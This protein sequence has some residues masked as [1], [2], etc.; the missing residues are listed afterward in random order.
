M[1][2]YLR[3]P[4]VQNALALYS[5]QV[6]EYLLPMITIPY[7]ARVLQPAAWGKIVYAQNF[8]FWIVMV[9]EYGFGFSASREIARHPGEAER[10]SELASGVAGAN[11]MLLAPALLL[12][13]I[14]RFT[15]PEF[16]DN[17][18]YLWLAAGIAVT[19]G[20]RPF[21]YFQGIERM[22][23]P[24]WMN[25]FGRFL[26]AAGIFALIRSAG[27]GWIVLTLQLLSGLLV[28]ALLVTSMYR[29]ISFRWP[30]FERSIAA[31]KVGW[32]IFLAR[33][34]TSL[35]TL[36]NT[37]ILGLF[38]APAAVAYY[39]G[40]ERVTLVVLGLMT[41]FTQAVYPRMSHL[42]ASNKGK[43]EDALRLGLLVFG[44]LGLV[45]GAV[46]IATAPWVIRI[47]LGPSYKPAVGVLRISALIVPL[48]AVKD[49]LG[50]Q[51]M[52]A[53]GMDR[54]FNRISLCAGVLNVFLAVFLS[55]RFG[56]QGTA[57]SVVLVQAFVTLSMIV[58]FARSRKF[59]S[60]QPVHS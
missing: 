10:H 47:L 36:A 60:A 21:W 29:R 19:T 46:L 4:V 30:N 24:A 33:S 22:K 44:L 2:R 53:F 16:R 1:K 31:L 27:Q 37:F 48:V 32:T 59:Q 26:Y 14:A 9:T 51:W 55:Q 28:T 57:W 38:A 45:G 35:Y 12:A 52:L 49:I 54:A 11:F 18:L 20:V 39:G 3:H 17:P 7:L 5:V 42:A 34:A 25:V 23:Y 8:A 41:P 40:A 50:M 56:P 58:L 43:A 13:V 6:A 15:V